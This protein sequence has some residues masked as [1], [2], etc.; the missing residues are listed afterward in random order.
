MF[1]LFYEQSSKSRLDL[2]RLHGLLLLLLVLSIVLVACET[3]TFRVAGIPT[4]G[5]IEDVSVS[6]IE[7][8]IR[9][10]EKSSPGVHG[11]ADVISHD[12]IWIYQ[13]RTRMNYTGM[14]RI[15]GKWEVGSVV[16]RHPRY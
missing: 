9:A 7:A 16:L 15:K 8:A 2:M 11:P 10:Y 14:F 4:Y 3:N 6:D 1:A 12:E 13:D 5:H